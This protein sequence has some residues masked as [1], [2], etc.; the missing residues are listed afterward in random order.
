MSEN[1][2]KAALLSFVISFSLILQAQ[3][4]SDPQISSPEVR[5]LESH[6]YGPY[7]YLTPL[8]IL[9]TRPE[10]ESKSLIVVSH[11]THSHHRTGGTSADPDA[12][13]Q[14]LT[15]NSDAVVVGSPFNRISALTS[16]QT[17]VFSDYEFRIE[18]ILKDATGKLSNSSQI[19]VTRPG[20]VVSYDGKSLRAID[21][22]LRLFEIGERYV[23]FLTRLPNTGT[24]R[25]SGDGAFPL[26]DGNVLRGN[27]SPIQDLQE[28]R[29]AHFISL[30][31]GFEATERSKR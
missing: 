24:Y 5:S 12:W 6:Q 22:E 31:Q 23:L 16:E 30:I 3:S 8:Q 15:S 4:T 21:P 13:I 20:G 26:R 28:S 2:K 17:F 18:S 7:A 11:S 27:S 25:V 29:E 14:E 19:V 10:N 1:S 9:L